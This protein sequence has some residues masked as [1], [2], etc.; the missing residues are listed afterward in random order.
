M[1]TLH[2]LLHQHAILHLALSHLYGSVGSVNSP[3]YITIHMHAQTQ[4][5]AEQRRSIH[6]HQHTPLHSQHEFWYPSE[7]RPLCVCVHGGACVH[8]DTASCKREYYIS[9]LNITDTFTTSALVALS[10]RDIKS[11][12]VWMHTF[13]NHF[14]SVHLFRKGSKR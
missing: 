9:T 3:Y 2:I 13:A 14:V 1:Y 6:A 8:F 12:S 10:T 11:M 5:A 4:T 7:K